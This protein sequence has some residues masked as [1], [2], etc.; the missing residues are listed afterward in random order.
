[1]YLILKYLYGSIG[2]RD[3]YPRDSLFLRIGRNETDLVLRMPV[4][5][6]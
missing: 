1:M 2:V 4:Y 6:L 3:F 5:A